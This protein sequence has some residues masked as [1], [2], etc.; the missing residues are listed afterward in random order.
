MSKINIKKNKKVFKKFNF[1]LFADCNKSFVK[2]DNNSLPSL[3]SIA[4]IKCLNNSCKQSDRSANNEIT[5]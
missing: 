1:T 2:E 4:F 5:G 3:D